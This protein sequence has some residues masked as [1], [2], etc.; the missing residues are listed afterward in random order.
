M[1]ATIMTSSTMYTLS[2]SL[3]MFVRLEWNELY[4]AINQREK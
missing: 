1:W 3:L 2:C 4:Y